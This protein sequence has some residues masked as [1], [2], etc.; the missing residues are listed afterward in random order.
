MTTTATG[1]YAERVTKRWL[2]YKLHTSVI[3]MGYNCPWDCWVNGHRVEIKTANVRKDKHGNRTWE[4]SIHRHNRLNET[5]VDF[6]VLRL[7]DVA[8][9]KACIY[10]VVPAPIKRK[11]VHISLRSLLMLW[12]PYVN[13]VEPL[14]VPKQR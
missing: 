11:T 10:L 9:F 4:F 6:Y 7:N 3:G 2:S 12:G 5:A 1:H 8:E 14:R 13:A